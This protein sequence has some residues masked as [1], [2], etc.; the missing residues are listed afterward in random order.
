MGCAVRNRVLRD[1]T[2]IK[3]LGRIAD[4]RTVREG[5]KICLK[6]ARIMTRIFKATVGEPM[7]MRRAKALAALLYSM[8]LFT[9]KNELNFRR[10]TAVP[11]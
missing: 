5:L 6:C 8:T 11:A 1:E 2:C 4:K 9:G 10:R 7:C 3:S